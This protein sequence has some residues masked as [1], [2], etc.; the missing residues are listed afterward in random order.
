MRFFKNSHNQNKDYYGSHF[1]S[2]A[3][4]L[5]GLVT[6]L[7]KAREYHIYLYKFFLFLSVDLSYPHREE[8]IVQMETASPMPMTW[9]GNDII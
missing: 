3:G 8:R 9:R 2:G 1:R 5:V 7:K 6:V 4:L